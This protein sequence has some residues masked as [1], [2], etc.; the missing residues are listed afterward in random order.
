MHKNKRKIHV[1]IVDDSSIFRESLA[2]QLA[3][4]PLIE[5]VAKAADPYMARDLILELRPDVMTLDVEM[6]RMNGIEFL[7]KL[8]PQYPIPVVVVSGGSRNSLEALQAGAAD[9]VAKPDLLNGRAVDAFVTELIIKI[10]LASTA[11]V[12]QQVSFS[13]KRPGPAGQKNIIAI[14]ASTGGTE[15]IAA[16]LKDFPANMPGTVIV[17]HMPPMFTSLFAAR[18]H[19]SCAVEVKEAK[20]GDMI[21]PGRV[22]IAPGDRHLR[23]KKAGEHYLAECFKSEKVNGH[24]PSVDVLFHSVAEHAGRNAIGV[25][26]TG[27]GCDG[28]AGLL[29]LR[30]KGAATLGQDEASSVV[31]G[32]P[33]AAFALGAVQEQAALEQMMQKLLILIN[34]P[35]AGELTKK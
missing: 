14:G 2:Q 21:V 6:P 11:R 5:V 10:K 26:L 3:G 24:C 20:T 23:I 1:L 22:L 13:N 25:I 17:Q 18:L 29:A 16:I 35:R 32:M 7:R 27:M 33:K 19:A 15:A 4:D 30:Q 31:Y 8:I 28:A 34:I 12:A 9:F